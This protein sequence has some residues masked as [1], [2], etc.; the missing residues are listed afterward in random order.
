MQRRSLPPPSPRSPAPTF[1]IDL[2]DLESR[3][4]RLQVRLHPD[5]FATM[6]EQERQNSADTS[7]AVNQ[8]YQVLKQ[9]LKRAQYM[10]SADK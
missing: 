3:Y 4:K 8:A 10:V 9:P 2:A 7:A 5:R 1:A 6:S